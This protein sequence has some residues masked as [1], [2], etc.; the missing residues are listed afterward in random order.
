MIALARERGIGYPCYP[1][2]PP[3][4]DLPDGF[5]WMTQPER[6]RLPAHF[7][8]LS[9]RTALLSGLLAVHSDPNVV[10]LFR[11]NQPSWSAY[12]WRYEQRLNRTD[13]S[14][15]VELHR[16]NED[17]FT[18]RERL[19]LYA[20]ARHVFDHMQNLKLAGEPHEPF[21]TPTD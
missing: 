2:S 6:E 13:V 7:W 21:S 15:K 14:G 5:T 9:D 8:R 19:N 12:R 18:G 20:T 1:D 4:W 3:P 16:L 17:F 11:F 10:V